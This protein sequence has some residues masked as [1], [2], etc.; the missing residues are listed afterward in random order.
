MGRDRGTDQ[1]EWAAEHVVDAQ[2]AGEL[3]AAQFPFLR[4]ASVEPLAEGWDNTVHLVGGRWAFRFPRRAIA[5]PGVRREIGLL[6][7]LAGRLPLP[8]PVPELVGAPI[9]DYPWPFWG[10]RLLPGREL[11]EAGLP[12]GRRVRMGAAVGAF[13]K[14]LHDPRHVARIGS[15]LVLD[16][17]RRGDPS[18]RI[19]LARERLERLERRGLW[20][21]DDAAATLLAE[22]GGLSLSRAEPVVAHGDLHVRHL[23]VDGTGDATGVI[24]WGDLCL[25]DA[26]VD[27]SVAYAAFSGEARA[28]LFAAYGPIDA[29]QETRA[30]VLAVYLSAVLADYAATQGHEALREEA[31]AGVRRAAGE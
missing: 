29:E 10:A 19:P 24:D 25:A 8:V 18:I 2:R 21:A 20:T 11:A 12:D 22:T 14:A 31:L 23:L 30:R 17:W 1:P 13:L 3:L 9:A 27:L 16:P 28:A 4:G 5:L 6:P 7:Q 15:H 26:A